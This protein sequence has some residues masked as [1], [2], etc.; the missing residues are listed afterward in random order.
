MP[1]IPK[2][3]PVLFAVTAI[4]L[5]GML[6]ASIW[7]GGQP[8]QRAVIAQQGGEPSSPPPGGYIPTEA[9]AAVAV[10]PSAAG[11]CSNAEYDP[12]GG[13][14]SDGP[15]L[16]PMASRP[17]PG[18][19]N[20]SCN[21]CSSPGS[22]GG[23]A[24]GVGT[25]NIEPEG[26][27]YPATPNW[28]WSG[29]G[30]VIYHHVMSYIHYADDHTMSA[31]GGLYLRRLHRYRDITEHGSFGLAG[32]SN[33]D[34][35]LHVYPF[36][37][38]NNPMKAKIRLIDVLASKPRRFYPNPQNTPSSGGAFFDY[39][40]ATIGNLVLKDA[41]GNLLTQ[42]E[43][44]NWTAA[45]TAVLTSLNGNVFTF[46]LFSTDPAAST[47]A[48]LAGRLASTRDRHGRGLTIAYKTWTAAELEESPERQWQIDTVTDPFG[49]VATFTYHPQQVAGQWVVS[50]VTFPGNV[51]TQY[52][53]TD[54]KLTH[55]SHPDGSESTFGFSFNQTS[56]STVVAIDDATAKTTHRRKRV[57]VGNHNYAGW[58]DLYSSASLL[59][60][61]VVNANSEVAYMA[62]SGQPTEEGRA[63]S[64][65]EGGGKMR[66]LISSHY[67][68]GYWS[69]GWT[70]GGAGTDPISGQLDSTQAYQQSYNTDPYNPQVGFTSWDTSEQ[71]IS[72]VMDRDNSG[73]IRRTTFGDQTYETRCYN[74]FFQTLRYRDRLGRVTL[75][76]YDSR[77]NMLTRT[78]GLGD[79]M[80]S[81]GSSGGGGENSGGEHGGGSS[82]GGEHGENSGGEHGGGSSGGGVSG[83]PTVVTSACGATDYQTA[84]FAVS[85]WEYYPEGHVNQF[86]LKAAIDPLG[87]RTD[88]EYNASLQLVKVIQPSDSAGSPR[89]ETT[90]SHDALGRLSSM[91]DSEGH[92]TS[93]VYDSLN[94]V[95]RIHHADASTERFFYGAGADA[96]L[97]VKSVDR[98]N[99]VT[100]YEYDA[101]GRRVR[102]VQ[103]S[104]LMDLAGNETAV[105]DP[106]VW[107]EETL[108]YLPGTSL[109]KT[110]SRQGETVENVY[111]YIHQVVETK[112]KPNTGTELVSKAKYIGNKLFLATDPHGRRTYHAYDVSN[113]R[114]IRM[115]QGATPDF[116]LT[117][118]NWDPY[119]G[120]EY[121]G[122]GEHGEGSTPLGSEDYYHAVLAKLREAENSP[123][124]K[125]LITDYLL[126]AEGQATSVID[127]RGIAST[128]KY[129]SRGRAIEQIQ[130]ASFIG[131][132]TLT[133]VP[134]K[135][136]TIYDAASRVMEVRSP[137][138]FDASDTNG[139][140]AAKTVMTYTGR[141]R[142][143]TRTEAP[144]TPQAAT[145]SYSY[146]I[147]GHQ[148][149]KTDA[150]GHVWQTLRPQCCGR[151]Q[152]SVDP[153]GHGTITRTDWN[154]NV[155]HQA[156]VADVLSHEN[157][158][159]PLNAKTLQEV[160]TKYDLRNRPV[161]RTVWLT[162][163]GAVV[164]T[165]PPIAGDEG[166][167]ATEGIT[168]RYQYDD[169]LTDGVGL[170]QQFAAH[171]AGLN[172]G[173]GC[174]GSAALVTNPEGERTLSIKD[175]LGRAVRSV[176][177]DANGAAVVSSTTTHDALVTI[178]GYGS[179]V[180]TTQSNALG[181]TSRTRTDGAGRVIESVDAE[182]FVTSFEYDAN[183]N[184]LKVRDP[185]GVGQDC[186]Y[187]ALNRDVSCS[188]TQELLS[189]LVRTKTYDLAG[190][191]T[192]QTD[193][194]GNSTYS[195]FDARGR[196]FETKDRNNATTSFT[197]DAAGN[198]LSMTDAENQTT[199]YEYD[200]LGRR[201]KIVWPDHVA[202]QNPGDAHCGFTT[203]AYDAAGRAVLKQDQLGETISLVYDMS[204][205]M[206]RREYRTLANSPVDWAAS[207]ISSA[208]S[209]GPITDQDTFTYDN[210]SRILAATKGR[211]SNTVSFTYSNGRKAT[212]SLAI[213]GQTY[214]VTSGYDQAGR[215][216]S[217][218][219]PD[220]TQVTR[221]HTAR[222]QLASVSLA[223][224]NAAAS[225]VATFTYDN[226][227]RETSR[228]YGNGIETTRA[229]Q[230]DNMLT[231][232]AAA[233]VETLIYTYDANKNPTSETRSGVMAAH[234]WSTG[235]GPSGSGGFDPQ[236]RLTNW[237]KANGDSQQWQ[238]S[239]VNDWQSF[240]NNGSTQTRTHGP[241][242]EL[243]A[244]T[245]AGATT[246]VALQHDPKGNLTQDDRG[247]LLTYDADN[248]LSAFGANNV[249]GLKNATYVYDALGRRVSKT[250]AEPSGS[251][252]TIYALSDQQVIAE[253]SS[254]GSGLSTLV[255][256]L[257]YGTYIDEPLVLLSNLE[258][259][260][261]TLYYHANRQYSTYTLTDATGT[262]AERYTYTPYGAATAHNPAGAP[263]GPTPQTSNRTL[264]TG[265]TLDIESTL[266]FFRARYV[267]KTLGRFLARDPLEYEDGISLYGALR[268]NPLRFTDASGLAVNLYGTSP[269][270]FRITMNDCD[271]YTKT[272]NP[273]ACCTKFNVRYVPTARDK[274]RFVGMYLKQWSHGS[275][276]FYNCPWSSP[277]VDGTFIDDP[278]DPGTG[279]S[280]DWS[281]SGGTS[282]DGGG[283][284]S[285]AYV[286]RND[287]PGLEDDGAKTLCGCP[288][289]C[290]TQ[291]L[292]QKFRGCVYGV[293]ANGRV[294]CVACIAWWHQCD[295]TYTLVGGSYFPWGG[296]CVVSAAITRSHEGVNPDLPS[297]PNVN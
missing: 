217:L 108:A 242:H 154:G 29:Q 62:V 28:M 216:T 179:V 102:T 124:S 181:H 14:C 219:Y 288:G 267:S 151:V 97:L 207:P 32:F 95:I 121:S 50:Q 141:G 92:E 117:V 144:G 145:E 17:A 88:Y 229:Y 10:S 54:G 86:L 296:T 22:F 247:C 197:H 135:T 161:A 203:V 57:Y 15:C 289:Y 175:G 137:R 100:N 195:Y 51:T 222:G 252:T 133:P 237:T 272:T 172:L 173:T 87:N 90:Y 295:F 258:S 152:L 93:Y 192:K 76:T 180:E 167:A 224:P 153:L 52:E 37:D 150:R 119:G 73:Y 114:L 185:N 27:G 78:V 147:A 68:Q 196:R 220:G 256:R 9:E 190:N 44:A 148:I 6:V 115:I 198:E 24:A 232:I 143:A 128:T 241:T 83:R 112:V 282:R 71:G 194:K 63:L 163:R 96:N 239:P 156:T 98:R 20:S 118:V 132:G 79:S 49:H 199:S 171:M 149:S 26:E 193:A 61:M 269:G 279:D 2:N 125:F 238:L 85:S 186:V 75:H 227:G 142:P 116:E 174:N 166:I 169:N 126:D 46:D 106:A 134:A 287:A 89:A 146:D 47:P 35:Q 123:N 56:Q 294:S 36:N 33:F 139:V 91:T 168:T 249:E 204:S 7:F 268:S 234:S 182:N 38:T 189:N 183:G 160:T 263:T 225:S 240:T 30:S 129:D 208:T 253:Y 273:G 64:I 176:Q 177:L 101:T 12:C 77:G 250:V 162:P 80:W 257:A 264:F 248:M 99:V 4:L 94:R 105:T 53:Y 213:F 291:K 21:T 235:T 297:D 254:S 109:V 262:P 205:R 276:W 244:I 202:G 255:S 31:P 280:T 140:N 283:P 278:A 259:Q 170:D 55:V 251:T 206:L 231:S 188:D 223:E 122:G 72:T 157:T 138:Y 3:R 59:I 228:L 270:T 110:R 271:S 81:A 261:S 34:T 58:G 43:G 120:G 41:S 5:L 16:R 211:Y 65:Y 245:N 130:S 131:T 285:P 11:A 265:R 74:E 103:A 136:E 243:T 66:K 127:P 226:G 212:E 292:K 8:Q 284:T 215:E 236:N 39:S 187:D 40:R 82:G 67:V 218:T 184:R 42:L 286:E 60:R 69:D 155:V 158:S 246:P 48:P 260:I 266:S 209:P 13:E 210:A 233:N 18:S 275:R 113:G 293:K 290:S 1:L 111:N 191:T 201:T 84:D 25:P 221:T 159:D 277:Q 200:P 23:S 230:A 107:S 104:A 45:K 70:L 274:S 281:A 178:A 165:D 19:N 164:F 214:T